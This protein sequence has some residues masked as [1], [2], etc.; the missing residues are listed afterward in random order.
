M[1]ERI[2]EIKNDSNSYLSF[3]IGNEYFAAHVAQIINIVE[4]PKITKVPHSPEY[5]LGVMNL[6]GAVLPVIDT[7]IKFGMPPS[8]ISSGTC[9]LVVDFCTK[10]EVFQGGIMVDAVSEVMEIDSSQ[11]MPT[12]NGGDISTVD[13]IYGI[14]SIDDYLLMLLDIDLLISTKEIAL[15]KEKIN[16]I[17]NRKSKTVATP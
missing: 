3:R 4:V 13:F 16:K 11:I 12:P 7:R 5:M 6:R 9:I 14:C 1:K 2:E 15:M 17:T 8:E 10:Q